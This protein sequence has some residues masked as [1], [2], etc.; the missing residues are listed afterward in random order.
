MLVTVATAT[1]SLDEPD[2]PAPE[3]ATSHPITKLAVPSPVAC[4]YRSSILFTADDRPLSL[5]FVRGGPCYA[6]AVDS[7]L[8]VK[9]GVT[10]AT[11][12]DPDAFVEVDAYG[13]HLA[14][15]VQASSLT[16]FRSRPF[17]VSGFVVPVTL[18]IV[19]GKP[20]EMVVQVDLD[21]AVAPKA[22]PERSVACDLLGLSS[23]WVAPDELLRTVGITGKSSPRVLSGRPVALSISPTGP[24]VATLRV[25]EPVDAYNTKSGATRIAFWRDSALVYGWVPSRSLVRCPP[26]SQMTGSG[27]GG[28]GAWV[29]DREKGLGW[30]CHTDFPIFV[31]LAGQRREVG[32]VE[33]GASFRVLARHDRR[34]DVIQTG[35]LIARRS[36][37]SPRRIPG[38]RLRPNAKLLARHQDIAACRD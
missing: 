15:V 11:G 22:P 10:V 16:L 34:F 33:A 28:G 13:T 23:G 18:R 29:T 8:Q 32:R 27:G 25:L 37:S 20:N 12:S 6:D 36:G 5:C 26:P 17:D 21:T 19:E 3:P 31:T 2:E 30:K 38:V 4:A 1:A 9:V 14:G 7:P 35:V 24:A